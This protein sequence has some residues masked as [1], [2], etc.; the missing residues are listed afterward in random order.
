MMAEAV[1][2][3][4]S[5]A[6]AEEAVEADSEVVTA[7]AVVAVVS[8]AVIVTAVAVEVASAVAEVAA[9]DLVEAAEEA[10]Q[11]VEAVVAVG[12]GIV[13]T[14]N[15]DLQH[16]SRTQQKSN[17]EAKAPPSTSL[18]TIMKIATPLFRKLPRPTPRFFSAAV[19]TM[20]D[21]YL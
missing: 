13:L 5:V 11:C 14:K 4:D 16:A 15:F 2:A 1:V 7:E 21:Q 9:A 19:E 18:R 20:S 6:V 10:V 3:E 8:E 12:T 17:Q